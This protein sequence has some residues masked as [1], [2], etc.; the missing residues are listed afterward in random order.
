L[1]GL[2][3]G[4]QVR[5]GQIYAGRTLFTLPDQVV[6]LV[7][8]ATN[9]VALDLIPLP[10][11]IYVNQTAFNPQ[12]FPLCVAVTDAQGIVKL[13]DARPDYYFGAPSSYG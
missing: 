1:A 7:A 13:T 12:S 6:S 5:G 10:P 8:N 11:A 2:N 4:E 3:F 9:Y